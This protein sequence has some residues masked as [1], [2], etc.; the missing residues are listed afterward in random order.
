[1]KANAICV[2]DCKLL[3]V[4]ADAKLGDVERA[5]RNMKAIY[6]EDSLA[7]YGLL[8]GTD[9]QEKLEE[10][11][12]AYGRIVN[13]FSGPGAKPP[14]SLAD[15]LEECLKQL[16][17]SASIGKF[18]R[19]V[20]ESSGF[21]LRDI[22]DRTKVSPMRLEQIEKEMFERL[23]VA[24]YVRGFVMGFAKVLGFAQPQE[25]AGL[26]LARYKEQVPSL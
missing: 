12:S 2:E 3:G 19:E 24:V 14:S 1:M 17:P 7:T 22:A 21:T 23:P 4:N 18:L 16:S 11:E 10:L 6:A 13:C 25:V 20:R 26:Y 9:R 5:W 8:E 15:N